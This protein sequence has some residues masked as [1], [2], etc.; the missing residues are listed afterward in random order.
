MMGGWPVP[1]TFSVCMLIICHT[2]LFG[3]GAVRQMDERIMPI[4]DHS[5]MLD[6]I[7][8]NNHGFFAFEIC[9]FVE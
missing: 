2:P 7:N 8:F 1:D 4:C 9:L 6:V 5:G 3:D